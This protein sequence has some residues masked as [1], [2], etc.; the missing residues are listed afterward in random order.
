MDFLVLPR[1]LALMM[2]TPLLC[3]YGDILG[4]LGGAL[5]TFTS[6]DI[7]PRMYWEQ[8]LLAIQLPDFLLG[9]VKSFFFG[10]LVSVSGCFCGIQSGRN[11]SAVGDAATSAV[12]TGIVLIVVADAIFAV[13]AALLKV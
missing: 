2:M 1:M 4:V 11:A 9:L 13:L 3:V 8:T 12:V 5:V 7:S 10:I 6:F